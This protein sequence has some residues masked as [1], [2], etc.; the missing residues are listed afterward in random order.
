MHPQ[1]KCKCLNLP[2]FYI[3]HSSFVLTLFIFKAPNYV[4]AKYSTI[5]FQLDVDWSLTNLQVKTVLK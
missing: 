3:P 1:M 4:L 2:N 5:F